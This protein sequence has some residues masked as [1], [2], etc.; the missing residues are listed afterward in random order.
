MIAKNMT[1]RKR[2]PVRGALMLSILIALVTCQLNPAT[3]V[4]QSFIGVEFIFDIVP[5]DASLSSLPATGTTF[6]IKGRVFPFRSVNQADCSFAVQSPRQVGT[7]RAWG[8]V[9]DDGKL[10][11]N[12]SLHL[13]LSR[14]TIEVQ[15]V[16]GVFLGT[17]GVS[18]V[19]PGNPTSPTTGPTEV[20]SVTGG[21]G[22]YRALNGEAHVRPYCSDP[23]SPFRYDRAFCL[24]V[25]EGRRR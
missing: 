11:M 10:V 17:G 13:D 19:F 18:R 5:D 9:A 3:G 23:S 14:G 15:G 24:S 22:V 1:S 8:S 20:L 6:F 25:V 16:T 12:Q 4:A 7:W 2:V 21:A